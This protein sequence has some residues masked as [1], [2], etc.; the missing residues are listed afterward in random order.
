MI[1]SR[2]RR[3]LWHGI[4][5]FLLIFSVSSCDFL[6]NRLITA[7]SS[8]YRAENRLASVKP[9]FPESEKKLDRI[10]VELKK[11]SG[12]FQKPTEIAFY[13]LKKR[14]MIILEK[15]GRA[16]WMDRMTGKSG[17]I[18]QIHVTTDSEQG[19]LGIAFHPGFQTNGKVYM[20]YTGEKN[21]KDVSWIVEWVVE[22]PASFP[23]TRWSKSKIIM[24]VEQPYANHN[25][26]KIA[27]G[28]D[29]YLYIGWGDGGWRGDPLKAGQD[30]TML[31]GKMLRID[32]N[33]TSAQ[34]AYGI[35][36]DNPFLKNPDVRPEIYAMGL[37]NPWKFSFTPEGQM[38][39]A[40]VGQNKYEEINRIVPGGNYGWNIREGYHCYEPQTGCKTKGLMDP[41]YEYTHAEGSSITGGAV[42]TG[43][44]IPK[45]KGK[46]VFADFSSGWIRAI[47]LP[48]QRR[49]RA[50]DYS[51][52]KWDMFL[53][54]F[55]Q[56]ERGELYL[57]D[58][59]RGDIYLLTG[60]AN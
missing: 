1:Q 18:F 44:L 10:D 11:V 56:D 9:T 47:D 57:A 60:P 50:K 36:P 20:N 2:K 46:Y 22:N 41:I 42:Y 26:G 15:G 35:P 37:R 52:G 59:G 32:V 49:Q 33:T 6:R 24:E 4:L 7:F 45:L 3:A 5:I 21:G 39:L 54:S 23:E 58:Y 31:L 48:K 55:G 17:T 19:L 29:G 51:L 53:V 30:P 13:P 38:I 40:D 25:A 8:S 16:L 28:P 14:Y 34:K 27:F 12:G 43:R